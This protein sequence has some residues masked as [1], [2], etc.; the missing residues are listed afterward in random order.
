MQP[1]S[2]QGLGA[3]ALGRDSFEPTEPNVAE[4]LARPGWFPQLPPGYS[5]QAAWGFHDAA[6]RSYDFFRVY[7]PSQDGGGRG[8]LCR[9]DEDRCFWSVIWPTFGP[10]ADEHIRGRWISFAQARDLIGS[11]LTFRQYGSPLEMCHEVPRLLHVDDL[12]STRH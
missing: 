5:E 10:A 11:Q 8:D 12:S 6:G 9:I 4:G 1:V 7:G 2:S 3:L